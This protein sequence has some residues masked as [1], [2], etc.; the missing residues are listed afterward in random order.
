MTV[1]CLYA[2]LKKMYVY[3]MLCDVYMYAK[4]MYLVKTYMRYVCEH[5]IFDPIEKQG[6]ALLS[7]GFDPAPLMLFHKQNPENRIP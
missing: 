3:C 2:V 1:C 6:T 4:C 5:K 7:A